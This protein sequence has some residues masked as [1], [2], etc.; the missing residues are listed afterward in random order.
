MIRNMSFVVFAL[1]ASSYAIAE[2]SPI[3]LESLIS[4]QSHY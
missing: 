4:V 2:Q 1:V 3:K